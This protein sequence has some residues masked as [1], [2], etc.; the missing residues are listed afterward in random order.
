MDSR[1]ADAEYPID[2]HAIRT[3]GTEKGYHSLKF[4]LSK[5]SAK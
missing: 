5:L 1:Y 2:P 3:Q 4:D